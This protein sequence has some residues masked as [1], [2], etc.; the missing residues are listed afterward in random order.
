MVSTFLG[1]FCKGQGA[2][3]F[4][5]PVVGGSKVTT[6]SGHYPMQLAK[7]IMQATER[8]FDYE[9]SCSWRAARNEM[10]EVNA[11]D[12]DLEDDGAGV[13]FH[14]EASDDEEVK[15]EQGE[16]KMIIS[17]VV[18]QAV[19]RLH[20]NTG[21]RSPARLARALLVCGAPTE[22][23]LAAKQL[24]CEVCQERKQPKTRRPA[25][26]P[27]PRDVGEQVHIDLVVLED[28][29]RQ[30]HY[31]VHVVVDAVSRYQAAAV[32][33]DKCSASVCRFLLQHWFPLMGPPRVVVA[34]QG[35]EFISAEFSE[36]LEARS[37]FLFHTA[38]QAPFQNGICERAGG[39]LKAL[40]GSI[41]VQHSV[42]NRDEMAD[43][44]AAAYNS[45]ISEFG[46]SPLQAVT[47]R[48]A[49]PL[50]DTLA[51]FGQR[52]AELITEKPSL[53]KQVA[54]RE[55]ARVSMVRLHYSKALR[56]A[57]SA[58]ARRVNVE[59]IPEPGDIVFF[60]QQTKVNPRKKDARPGDS[61]EKESGAEALAWSG[62][63]GGRGVPSQWRR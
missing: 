15:A 48:Q 41:V 47:G 34:D 51:D 1:K 58:R 46:T 3:H 13:D 54:M 19:R 40:V 23:V 20:E 5:V 17:K 37:V 49:L 56:R 27:A 28:G 10:H 31:V 14:M 22:A 7:A 53:A 9:T 39:V 59:E 6:K 52:L 57:E 12:G 4:H 44:V 38:V 21:H 2:K 63:D 33:E 35:R 8:Q 36:F 42:L 62:V 45:D 30:G 11:V 55:T 18:R 24:H 61:E 60:S 32:I 16:S 43:A 50:G 25:K 26:L 29:L